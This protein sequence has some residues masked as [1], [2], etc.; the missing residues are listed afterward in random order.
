MVVTTI[1]SLTGVLQAV[2]NRSTPSISTTQMRQAPVVETFFNQQSVGILIPNSMA[3]S[4]MVVPAGTCI[5]LPSIVSVTMCILSKSIT[6][7][8]DCIY[9]I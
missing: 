6:E 9:Q 3:A 4:R 1:P 7:N 5:C 2:M 8:K